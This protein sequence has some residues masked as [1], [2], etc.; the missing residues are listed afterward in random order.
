[1]PAENSKH[2]PGPW[3]QNGSHIYGA[4]PQRNI[5]AQIHY[6]GR[7]YQEE[8]AANESLILAAPDLLEAL[9]AILAITDR[10][11]CAWAQARAA[12]AKAT[13]ARS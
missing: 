13:E 11:H 9:K 6:I 5:V 8:S 12:I 10:D 4:D 1:M 3:Q 7:G 2:T